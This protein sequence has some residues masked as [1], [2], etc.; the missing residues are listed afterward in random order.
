M[1]GLR[2][3]MAGDLFTCEDVGLRGDDIEA[4]AFA[5]LAVRS[6]ENLPLTFPGTTGVAAP[7]GGGRLCRYG[8]AA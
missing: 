8:Q 5:Y 4:E 1:D 2:A 7:T 3:R 6:L